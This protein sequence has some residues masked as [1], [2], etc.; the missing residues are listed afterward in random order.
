[1]KVVRFVKK[2]CEEDMSHCGNKKR[3]RRQENKEK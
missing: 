3:G 2:G 1:M